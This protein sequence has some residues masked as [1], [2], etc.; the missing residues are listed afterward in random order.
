V[1]AWLAQLGAA[2]QLVTQQPAA[3]AAAMKLNAHSCTDDHMLGAAHQ[4]VAQQPAAAAAEVV[5]ETQHIK[6][7]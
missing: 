5:R 4:L 1:A 3:A 2:H 7:H 6:T